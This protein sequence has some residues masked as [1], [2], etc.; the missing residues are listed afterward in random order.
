ML[1]LYHGG[2]MDQRAPV[3]DARRGRVRSAHVSRD[4]LR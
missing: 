3:D 1:L 4:Y 2:E